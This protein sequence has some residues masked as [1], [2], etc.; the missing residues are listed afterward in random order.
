[1]EKKITLA[2]VPK[3]E[4][5]ILGLDER[6]KDIFEAA[7]KVSPYFGSVQGATVDAINYGDGSVVLSERSDGNYI[8]IKGVT[9]VTSKE[10]KA[11][12]TRYYFA[13]QPVAPMNSTSMGQPEALAIDNL[14]FSKKLGERHD[15]Y[16]AH[17]APT[18][19]VIRDRKLERILL[20]NAE[21]PTQEY[22]LL[23][24]VISVCDLYKQK[25]ER[26]RIHRDDKLWKNLQRSLLGIALFELN[27]FDPE[28]RSVIDTKP[29]A[30][31]DIGKESVVGGDGTV[32]W[33]NLDNLI[34]WRRLSKDDKNPAIFYIPTY[35]TNPNKRD[36]EYP[37]SLMNLANYFNY[38]NQAIEYLTMIE[39]TSTHKS[40]EISRTEI[41]D[42]INGTKIGETAI[43][44]K[45]LEV[46]LET[47]H[48]GTLRVHL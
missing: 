11:K 16:G 18:I 26:E 4:I 13:S 1:M 7:P 40:R 37:Q 27:S 30:G 17:F 10:R 19:A 2:T 12:R 29:P 45:G 47:P 39:Q 24:S 23:P 9:S 14:N 22:V 28:T 44:T 31:S 41:L 6:F 21:K 36:I 35:K 8:L 33:R 20:A 3:E 5:T 42:G 46:Y 15:L 25:E 38:L 34:G 48:I 43:S 32:Y